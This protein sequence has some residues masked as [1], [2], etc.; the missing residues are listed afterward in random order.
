MAALTVQYKGLTGIIRTLNLDTANTLSETF[1][2]AISDEGLT[3]GYYLA[4]ALEGNSAINTDTE[5]SNTLADLNITASDILYVVPDQEG[6]LEYRQ[7][8]RIDIAKLKRKGGPSGNVSLPCYRSWNSSNLS[9]LP[10]VY[11]GNT[12]V[13]NPHPDGLE[14]GRPWGEYDVNLFRYTYT[15]YFADDPDWFASQTPTASIADGTLAVDPLAITTSYQWI[16]YFLPSTTETYTFYT[17]SDDASFLWIGSNAVTGFT[18][19]N[20]L[21]N[22]GGEHGAEERSGSISLTAGV[23]YPIRIQAGNNGGPGSMLTSFSTPTIAK[24]TTFTG[25]LFYEPDTGGF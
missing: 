8:Q 10:S 6:T 11:V 7:V 1:S 21:V 12:S 24:T 5:G 23:Y 17:T 20:S 2:A 13:P 22:N 4:M 9:L 15:G 18:T 16:G 3:S 25:Y 19:A 14:Q